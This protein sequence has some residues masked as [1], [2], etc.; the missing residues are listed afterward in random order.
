MPSVA[1]ARI[2]ELDLPDRLYPALPR[3]LTQVGTALLCVGGGGLLRV[4]INMVA[5]G[6]AVF[7]LLLPMIMVATLFARWQAGL[8]TAAVSNVPVECVEAGVERGS[9]EPAVE[10]RPP[11]VQDR[12]RRR[13]PVDGHGRLAPEAIGVAKTAL[14][15]RAV[16]ASAHEA[17]VHPAPR[18]L[19]CWHRSCWLGGSAAGPSGR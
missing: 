8:L 10:R 13:D 7:V 17:I 12:R 14:V 18:W 19:G 9:G 5:P 1:V 11:R 16:G 6:S 15:C 4:L 2:G 3:W